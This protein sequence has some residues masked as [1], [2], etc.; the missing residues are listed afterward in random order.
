MWLGWCFGFWRLRFPGV[1]LGGSLVSLWVCL[2]GFGWLWIGRL[3]VSCLGLWVVVCCGFCGLMRA[4]L[5]WR[6]IVG[7]VGGLL[8][9]FAWCVVLLNLVFDCYGVLYLDWCSH[10]AGFVCCW[11]RSCCWFYDT[12][13]GCWCCMMLRSVLGVT[14]LYFGGGFLDLSCF[15]F[16]WGVVT[17]LWVRFLT[18]CCEHVRVGGWFVS[19]VSGVFAIVG[20]GFDCGCLLIV[21]LCELVW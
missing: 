15:W 2:D 8:V 1:G 20:L 18:F 17:W 6:G 9:G 5:D 16:T 14:W 12:G 10:V 11:G 4:I 3:G 19:L 7:V 21:A 13:L